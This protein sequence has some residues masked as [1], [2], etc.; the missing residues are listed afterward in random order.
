LLTRRGRYFLAGPPRFSATSRTS[1]SG[2]G[3]GGGVVVN[4]ERGAIVINGAKG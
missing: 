2:G 1:G 3:G 4:V